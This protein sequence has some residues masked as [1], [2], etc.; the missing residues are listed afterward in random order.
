MALY[1]REINTEDGDRDGKA[2]GVQAYKD[3]LRRRG[4][5]TK[6]DQETPPGPH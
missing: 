4:T 3:A 6:V 1:G 5:V 2:V